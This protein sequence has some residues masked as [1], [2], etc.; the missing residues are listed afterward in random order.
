[1]GGIDDL[2]VEWPDERIGFALFIDVSDLGLSEGAALVSVHAN[3][4]ELFEKAFFLLFS[5]VA[6]SEAEL[7]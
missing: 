2:R 5:V 4:L 3:V 6:F 1:M 7:L